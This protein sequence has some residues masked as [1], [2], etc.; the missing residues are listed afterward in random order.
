MLTI[1]MDHQG[2]HNLPKRQQSYEADFHNF[3]LVFTQSYKSFCL[4]LHTYYDSAY[5]TQYDDNGGDILKVGY[6]LRSSTD[7]GVDKIRDS[8]E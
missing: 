4:S 1:A 2:T 5:H 6:S 8:C 3:C 7:N